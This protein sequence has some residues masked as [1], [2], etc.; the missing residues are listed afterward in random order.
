VRNDPSSESLTSTPGSLV[1]TPQTGDLN[2]TTNTA[3][4]IL[5]QSAP[6]D[7]TITS[8]LAFSSA[9]HANNQQGGIIAYQDDDD[10]LKLDWEFSSGAARFSETNEDSLSGA[11]VAQVLTTIPTASIMGAG[12]TVW[13]RMVK[14]GPIYTTSYSTDGVSFTPIYTTGAA[15]AN[16]KAGVFAYNRAGTTSDL[17]VAFDDFTVSP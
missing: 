10:Y 14:R 17:N 16:V 13:L 15:L 4:N 12:T 9:P 7:W 2:T 5:V 3:R 6:G 8:K 1:I 11:P